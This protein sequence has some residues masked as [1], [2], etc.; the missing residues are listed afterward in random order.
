MYKQFFNF[1]D[2]PFK[3]DI[4]VDDFYMSSNLKETI[5]R[6][7]F[8]KQHRGFMLLTGE[9]GTAKLPLYDISLKQLTNHIFTPFTCN[10]LPYQPLNSIVSSI[11]LSAVVIFI[12]N[13]ICLHQFN[14]LYL[15]FPLIKNGYL[16]L[17]WTR[18]NFWKIKYFTKYNYSLI[19]TLILL[20]LL[21]LLL[22]VKNISIIYLKDLLTRHCSIELISFLISRFS[23]N[24]KL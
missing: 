23:L 19:L 12:K 8:L 7:E 5:S 15:I 2:V 22:L 16:L 11:L 9:S 10:S 24:P 14:I 18:H 17:F 21:S 6:F 3:K 1:I 20:T 4:S 13:R